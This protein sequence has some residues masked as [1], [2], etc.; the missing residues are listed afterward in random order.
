[1]GNKSNRGRVSVGC[2]QGS[3]GLMGEFDECFGE[4]ERSVGGNVQSGH[5]S[6]HFK[7]IV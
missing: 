1:M 6:G 2:W 5:F 7:G 3:G 4:E